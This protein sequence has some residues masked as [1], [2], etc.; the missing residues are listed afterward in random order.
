MTSE[1]S[2]DQE[3]HDWMMLKAYEIIKKRKRKVKKA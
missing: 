1:E 3:S 2:V